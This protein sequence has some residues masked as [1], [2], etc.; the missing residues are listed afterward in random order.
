MLEGVKP[1]EKKEKR[2]GDLSSFD[3]EESMA[4]SKFPKSKVTSADDDTRQ[5]ENTIKL[6]IK[7]TDSGSLD[8]ASD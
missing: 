2:Y 6:D 7:K 1:K 3:S 4:E 5:C 8:E